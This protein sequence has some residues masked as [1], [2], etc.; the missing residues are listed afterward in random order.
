[1]SK[2]PDLRKKMTIVVCGRSGSGKGTQA[3]FLVRYLGAKNVGR[4]ETGKFLRRLIKKDNVTAEIGREC[5]GN[6]KLFPSWFALYGW[7][8]RIIEYGD[9]DK[10]LIFD[11]WPRTVWQA[12]FTDDLVRWHGRPDAIGVYIDVPERVAVR[13]LL[14]RNRSDDKPGAIKN[15]MGFFRRDMVPV[16]KYYRRSGRLIRVDGTLTP[17]EVFADI[18]KALERRLKGLWPR[19]TH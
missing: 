13:R 10:H 4:M 6:G 7:L 12:E 11:G 2:Q 1:M 3:D 16:L 8:K 14:L 5:I 15:R 18:K 9:A 17:E 19:R